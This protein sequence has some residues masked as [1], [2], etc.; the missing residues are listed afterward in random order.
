MNCARRTALLSLAGLA[1][2]PLSWSAPTSMGQ[3]LTDF[4]TEVDA[5]DLALDPQAA[6]LRGD[7]RHAGQFG[8]LISDDHYRAAESLLRAQLSAFTAI[9][10]VQLNGHERVAYDMWQ[11]QAGYALRQYDEGL[12]KI[13]RRLPVDHLLGQHLAFAQFSSGSTAPYRTLADYADGLSRI[14]GFVVYLDRAIDRMREGMRERHV[15]LRGITEKVIAQLDEA[16]A[17]AP[18][19]SPFFGPI[20]SMPESFGAADRERLR[21]AYRDAISTKIHP[22]F[23]RLRDFMRSEYLAASRTGA[24]G[25]AALPGG[26]AY[27]EYLL[28]S[29][30]TLRLEA[31]AIHRLGLAEVARIRGQ[32]HRIRKHVGFNGTLA[33]FFEHLK[34]DARFKFASKEALLDAYKQVGQRVDRVLPTLFSKLPASRLEFAAVPAEQESS[35]SGA[36]YIVGTADGDRPGVFYVNTSQLPTRTSVRMT[37]LYLHEAMPGHH[38]QASLAQE[39]TSLPPTLRFA[40]NAGYGEG[41]ALYAEWLGHEM[42][43]YDDPYQHFGQLDMEIFRAAR[44]VVDTG[45]HAQGWSRERAIDY[46]AANTS[47]DR[48]H[49]ALEVDRYIVWPGQACAYKLG[50]IKIRAL[51]RQ[52][53]HALGLRFDVREFHAQVLGSGALP[54]AVLER[55]INDWTRSRA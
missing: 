50:D 46:L 14:D 28:E 43:L 38:L 24:P 42:G 5:Q 31:D 37:A 11:Y 26:T 54:L 19:A 47:L 9:D 13:S 16:L 41:W 44:M 6:V 20:N 17:M 36:Y 27:Y 40:W 49:I 48:D 2:V 33:Q 23:M 15:L 7:L 34:N 30:T 35:A 52:A 18:Q 10:R 53:Q 51:R 39:D 1:W 21:T 22:A 4:L 45:L 12:V 25:L 3:R 32:M 8:D 55:K 29:H